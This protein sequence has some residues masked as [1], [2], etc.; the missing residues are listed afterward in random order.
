[1]CER[2]REGGK[3]VREVQG[4]KEVERRRCVCVRDI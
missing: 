2:E 3:K 4:W 1:M